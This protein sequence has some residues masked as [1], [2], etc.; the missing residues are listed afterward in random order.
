[1]KFENVRAMWIHGPQFTCQVTM[2]EVNSWWSGCWWNSP[3]IVRQ[4][5][6]GHCLVKKNS[7]RHFE[8][9]FF[10]TSAS[11]TESCYRCCCPI[12][13]SRRLNE[14]LALA[15]TFRL[16]RQRPTRSQFYSYHWHQFKTRCLINR[17]FSNDD[18]TLLTTT[19]M[20]IIRSTAS[21]EKCECKIF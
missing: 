13:T 2:T 11:V 7:A 4:Q 19:L 17:C 14:C 5:E 10:K 9:C 8:F 18:V 21:Q 16:S 12:W 1:M 3:Q 20:L 15:A 6:S